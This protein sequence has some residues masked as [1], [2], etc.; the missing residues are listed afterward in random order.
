M[1]RFL[2]PLVGASF[3]AALAAAAYLTNDRWAPWLSSE[4]SSPADEK[5]KQ[6]TLD[7]PKLL[8]LSSQARKNLSLVSKPIH[9]QSYWRTIQVPGMIVDRPGNSD[10]GVTAPAVGVVVRVRAVPGDIVKPGD[11]LFTLRLSSEY[12]QNVQS[13]L[14]KAVNEVQL[15]K[16]ELDRLSGFAQN[17]SLPEAKLIELKFQMRRQNTAIQVFRQDLLA[18]GLTPQQVDRVA[19]GKFVSEIEVIAPLPLDG[20]ST[21]VSLKNTAKAEETAPVYEV[22]DLKVE[23]GQQVQAGQ[24]L[25]L[26]ANHHSL[27]IEGRSFRREAPF[28]EA[29]AKNGWPIHVDFDEDGDG[30]WPPLKQT[31][32]IRHLANTVDPASRTFDFF[33]PLANQ[34]R[35]YAKD[36]KTFLVWQFRPGQRVR[37]NV[38]VEEFKDVIVLPAAAVVREGPEAYAFRQNGDLFERRAV[39]VLHED[40]FNVV[41]ANDGALRPGIDFLAQG[42]AASLNRVLKAQNSSGGLPPGAHFHADGSLH[43]PGK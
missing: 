6:E 8:K 23:L 22:R 2:K 9:P 31:L 27:F 14:I 38:P 19:D 17:G 7:E 32:A 33:V 20:E 11:R 28:L 16:E 39:H 36:G 3:I 1:K 43:I 37:L 4:D 5:Q 24:T 30:S 10:R 15:L 18:R 25:C 41:L 13:E 35:S 42:S 29:A 12:L 21:L 40:R 34:A 26:L